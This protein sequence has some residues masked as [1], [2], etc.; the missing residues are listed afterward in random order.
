M[1]SCSGF[2]VW[3]SVSEQP[4]VAYWQQSKHNQS[5]TTQH[6][7]S[8]LPPATTQNS[9]FH[10]K[11]DVRRL[12]LVLDSELCLFLFP[13]KNRFFLYFAAV[14]S[15]LFFKCEHSDGMDHEAELQIIC[16]CS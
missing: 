11:S 8:M 7:C 4:V 9:H 3:C 14:G 2:S 16:C 5:G 1:S 12:C 6:K 13:L 15:C 10:C